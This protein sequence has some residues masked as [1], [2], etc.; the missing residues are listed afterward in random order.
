MKQRTAVFE[1]VPVA[2][3][4]LH[5]S[6]SVL[7]LL[8]VAHAVTSGARLVGEAWHTIGAAL[9][10]DLLMG[11]VVAGFVLVGAAVRRMRERRL[12]ARPA[13]SSPAA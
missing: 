6:A 8:V 2:T 10:P 9:A 3:R 13:S 4:A 7:A 5:G 11:A 1:E 12:T